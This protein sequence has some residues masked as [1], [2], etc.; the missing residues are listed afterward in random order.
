MGLP[1][2]LCSRLPPIPQADGEGRV[3]F[4][5]VDR[6]SGVIFEFELGIDGDLGADRHLETNPGVDDDVGRIFDVP[7]PDLGEITVCFWAQNVAVHIDIPTERKKG[8]RFK[9]SSRF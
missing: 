5:D 4:L 9:F 2:A 1:G 6:C 8:F 3:H 7:H